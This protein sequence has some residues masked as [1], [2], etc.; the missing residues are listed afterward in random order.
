MRL[1]ISAAFSLLLLDLTRSSGTQSQD[2]GGKI[3]LTSS[4]ESKDELLS[5][6]ALDQVVG[7]ETIEANLEKIKPVIHGPYLSKVIRNQ[8]E[9]RPKAITKTI[10]PCHRI[11]ELCLGKLGTQN[12]DQKDT[13]WKCIQILVVEGDLEM[14]K[15]FHR[16]GYIVN[17]TEFLRLRGIASNRKDMINFFLEN[18]KSLIDFELTVILMLQSHEI[19]PKMFEYLVSKGLP[20]SFKKR[21][22]NLLEVSLIKGNIAMAYYFYKSGFSLNMLD[23]IQMDIYKPKLRPE[24][25]VKFVA[26]KEKMFWIYQA[27]VDEGSAFY[28]FPNDI[29][30]TSISALLLAC[31]SMENTEAAWLSALKCDDIRPDLFTALVESTQLSYPERNWIELALRSGRFDFGNS[32][33]NL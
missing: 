4:S 13:F 7:L 23:S 17:D 28:E 27:L 25:L 14:V 6:H 33:H 24:H 3:L 22:F 29:V 9:F 1:N 18:G 10:T 19:D 30:T 26:F 8:L 12:I 2:Q 20:F 16:A 15:I 21:S 5:L 32:P 11:I 31:G